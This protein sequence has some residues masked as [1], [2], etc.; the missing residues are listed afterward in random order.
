[1]SSGDPSP[2][3]NPTCAGRVPSCVAESV[4]VQ[5]MELY[6]KMIYD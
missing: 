3:V 5:P 6:R 1:M 2:A 4:V